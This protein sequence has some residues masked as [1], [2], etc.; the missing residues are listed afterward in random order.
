VRLFKPITQG[1]VEPY[2]LFL[3]PRHKSILGE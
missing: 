1:R 3:R 2:P